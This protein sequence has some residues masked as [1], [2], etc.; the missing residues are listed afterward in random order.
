MNPTAVLEDEP[1]RFW[2]QAMLGRHNPFRDR[3][4]RIVVTNRH[5]RS[6]SDWTRVEFRGHEMHRRAA[7]SNCV[8]ECSPLCVRAGE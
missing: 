4:G 6:E 2:I 8:L 5:G 1:D 3:L 7:N